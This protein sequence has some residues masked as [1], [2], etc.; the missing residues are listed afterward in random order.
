MEAKHIEVELRGPLTS[1]QSARLI[2]DL[3]AKGTFIKQT[4]RIFIDYSVFIKGEG[5][6]VRERDVRVR[7]TNGES[8]IMIKTGSPGSYEDRREY[9][10]KSKG[11]FD[12]LVQTMAVL[13]FKRGICGQRLGRIYDYKGCEIVVYEVPEHSYYYEVDV[14]TTPKG[15]DK[16]LKKLK[17]ICRELGLETFTNEALH[18]YMDELNTESNFIY[19][20][21]VMPD[22]YFSKQY[23][24]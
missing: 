20:A 4:K 11:S 24:L 8:E 23:G 15:K 10:V 21:D 9:S 16:A 2:K 5:I 1:A 7:V 18:E 12:E 3:D 17:G 13:G 14:M 19:D 22:G 6:R